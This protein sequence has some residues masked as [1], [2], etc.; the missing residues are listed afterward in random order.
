MTLSLQ[1]LRYTRRIMKQLPGDAIPLE[2][3]GKYLRRSC[4]GAQADDLR[5]ALHA[6]SKLI[7]ER[8]GYVLFPSV[9]EMQLDAFPPKCP[10]DDIP[11]PFAPAWDAE[12]INKW[13]ETIEE[14]GSECEKKF[15]KCICD[16]FDGTNGVVM[17]Y[18]GCT[19]DQSLFR[20]DSFREPP[21]LRLNDCCKCWPCYQCN[22]EVSI[23]FVAGFEKMRY[24]EPCLERAIALIANDIYEGKPMSQIESENCTFF[25]MG[26]AG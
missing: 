23:R 24:E 19:V 16:E 25:S 3:L 12:K 5:S 26:F 2:T 21:R 10:S 11:L 4:T 6:A 7:G 14:Y 8:T 1:N 9:V 18:G 17:T 20:L 13:W 22:K 15:A